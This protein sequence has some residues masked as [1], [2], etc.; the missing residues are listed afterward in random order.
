[1]TTQ[2]TPSIALD[3][4][5]ATGRVRRRDVRGIAIVIVGIGIALLGYAVTLLPTQGRVTTATEAREIRRNAVFDG[6]ASAAVA[7]RTAQEAEGSSS[8]PEEQEALT[9]VRRRL[10]AGEYD[11]ALDTLN[12]ARSRIQHLPESYL[13]VGFALLGKNDFATAVDFFNAAIDRDPTLAEGYF[14]YAVAAEGLGDIETA[15]GGMRSFLHLQTNPDPYRLK[16]AQARS[17]IWEWEARLGRGVWGASRGVPPGFTEAELRRDGR[18]VGT[19]IPIPGTTDENGLSRY[20][21]KHSDHIKT[22]EK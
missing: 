4:P 3:T 21:I 20:T 14:G 15:L 17:A 8:N 22:F 16:V 9:E 10:E 2:G 18:G 1:M 5:P 12:A 6:L 7:R 19:K 13:L 11:K